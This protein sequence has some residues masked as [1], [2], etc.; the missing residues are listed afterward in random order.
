MKNKIT[1]KAALTNVYAKKAYVDIGTAG[2]LRVDLGRLEPAI[3]SLPFNGN[4]LFN[5]NQVTF[6]NEGG[7]FGAAV[8]VFVG[9]RDDVLFDGNQSEC[10]MRENGVGVNTAILGRTIRVNGNQLRET[11]GRAMLSGLTVGWLLNT[12]T[13][14]QSIH[15]LRA[16]GRPNGTADVNNLSV[17]ESVAGGAC[18]DVGQREIS[19]RVTYKNYPVPGV[20]V[21]VK[22]TSVKTETGESG[23]Y[24]LFA[25]EGDVIVV[26]RGPIDTEYADVR[27]EVAVPASQSTLDIKVEDLRL[28]R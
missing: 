10:V 15:C 16:L 8:S 20:R 6:S 26:F 19:G 12:T 2:K 14:N 25:P 4:V 9:S 7:G 24:Q 13:G 21:H 18:S 1:L 3:P 28:S 22:G 23:E 27:S 11:P 17:I 5:D